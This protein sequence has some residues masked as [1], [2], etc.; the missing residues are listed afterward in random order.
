MKLLFLASVFLIFY[1]YFGYLGILFL[2]SLFKKEKIIRENNFYPTVSLIITAHNEEKRIKEKLENT[3]SLEYPKEKLEIIVAS[4]CSTDKTDQIVKSFEKEGIRLVRSYVRKGKEFAQKIAID[5]AKGEI[6]VFSDVSTLLKKDALKKIVRNFSDSSVGCVSSVDRLITDE[7]KISGE[8]LYVRYEMTIR[9]LESKVNSLVGLSG[10]FFAVRK[11]LCKI[12][13]TDLP[14]DFYVVFNAIRKKKRAVLDEEVIGFYKDVLDEEKEFKR[15]V[16]TIL[17]GI[18]TLFSNLDML[19]PFKYKLFSWQLFS[20]KFLRWTAPYFFIIAF[21]S[22]LFLIKEDVFFYIFV[23]QL[24]FYFI[25]ILSSNLSKESFFRKLSSYF[26]TV[27]L[28]TIIA[29][30]KFLKGERAILW[31]PSQRD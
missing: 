2:I 3:I 17:R 19:N 27:N 21:V 5:I 29:W 18:T 31:E 12:W 1:A 25:L 7:G 9:K 22:N 16:R 15:K 6:L 14:S 11:E 8:G 23:L 30:W 26:F 4:D 28:A 20:H 13:K 10:S 24:I